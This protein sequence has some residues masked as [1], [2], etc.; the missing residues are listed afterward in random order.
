MPTAFPNRDLHIP[1]ARSRRDFLLEAGGGFGALALSWLLAR[2]GYAA[3]TGKTP[4]NPL[5]AKLP[6]FEA[7]AKS[8]IFMFMVGGPSQVDLFDPKPELQKHHGQPLPESFGKPVS[9]F[10]KGDTP[11]LA[12]TRF[13]P[14]RPLRPGNLRPAAAPGDPGG[15]PLPAALLLVHQYGPRPR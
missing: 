5:A 4:L 7:K 15:R 3:D 9:Q 8:V 12:S 10:T 11:L 1:A 6:H 2:D 14:A 13:R